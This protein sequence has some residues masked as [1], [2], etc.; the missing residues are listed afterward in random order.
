MATRQNPPNAVWIGYK[1]R[2]PNTP[3][4]SG[5]RG[6]VHDRMNSCEMAAYDR[7]VLEAMKA[8]EAL[9]VEQRH[10]TIQAKEQMARTGVTAS[11][12]VGPAAL[13]KSQPLPG[14]PHTRK[15]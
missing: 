7:R 11:R 8:F 5:R 9:P 4:P 12:P 13:E 2:D 6:V 15:T 3:P 1:S 10:M 14:D